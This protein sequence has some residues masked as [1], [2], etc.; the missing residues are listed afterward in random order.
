[1]SL[2]QCRLSRGPNGAL[3]VCVLC[4]IACP[5]LVLVLAKLCVHMET[6]TVPYVVEVLAGAFQGRGLAGSDGPPRFVGGEVARRLGSTASES[7][8]RSCHTAC[9]HSRVQGSLDGCV[10]VQDTVS[11][12][13]YNVHHCC[14]LRPIP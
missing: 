13:R 11:R 6:T 10:Q 7:Q 14:Q 5:G 8:A 1:M 4:A 3:C 2:S 12:Q 9:L